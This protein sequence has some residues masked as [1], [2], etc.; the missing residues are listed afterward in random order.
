MQRISSLGYEQGMKHFGIPI[1]KASIDK[2]ETSGEAFVLDDDLDNN[3]IPFQVVEV[4]DID[5]LKEWMGNADSDIDSGILEGRI[6]SPH[7][8][9]KA[10][11]EDDTTELAEAARQYV[12]GHSSSVS[13]YRKR[14]ENAFFPFHV[15]IGGAK[16]IVVKAGSPLIIRGNVPKIIV[17]DELVF[18]GKGA[19][20]QSL[21]HL[22]MKVKKVTIV[23]E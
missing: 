5:Q 18:E 1:T 23:A 10:N 6:L 9:N 11:G 19:R 3:P 7:L 16:R 4:T 12:F 13:D 20:I 22:S 17:A 21:V 15:A 2:I 14:I 8:G